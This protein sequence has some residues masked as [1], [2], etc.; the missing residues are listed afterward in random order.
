MAYRI[1]DAGQTSIRI[2]G[3][4]LILLAVLLWLDRGLGILFPALAAAAIHELGHFLAAY[5]L[6]GTVRRIN[7]TVCGAEMSFEEN[8]QFF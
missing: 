8:A 2:S 1:G 5:L 6:G 7:L 3:G 4:F